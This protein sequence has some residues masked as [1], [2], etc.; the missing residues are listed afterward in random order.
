MSW[1]F[2]STDPSIEDDP[3]FPLQYRSYQDKTPRPK[4]PPLAASPAEDDLATIADTFNVY[5]GIRSFLSR[6]V[7]GRVLRIDTFSKVFGPGVRLGWVTAQP[8]F[9]EKLIR[10]GETSTQVPSNISQAIL[11]SYLSDEHWGLSG[12]LRWVWSVRLEYERKRDFFLDALARHAPGELVTTRPALAGMFQWLRVDIERHPRFTSVDGHTNTLELT[13]KLSTALIDAGV[14]VIPARLFHV[15]LPDVDQSD[16]LNYFRAT[17]SD[18]CS[19]IPVADV[20]LL[21]TRTLLTA[22]LPS[23][24]R[25]SKSSLT[26]KCDGWILTLNVNLCVR[27][28]VVVVVHAMTWNH[29]CSTTVD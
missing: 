15:P 12:W 23:L 18:K 2:E 1:S 10:T 28:A 27:V 5:A 29:Q 16:R 19:W 7:D 3:Y 17:V 9:V 22:R 13:D 8:L 20:S 25:R 21:G 14:L 24:A 26:S 4:L 11:A 6:D